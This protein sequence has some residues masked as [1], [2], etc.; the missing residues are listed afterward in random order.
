MLL[1]QK[2]WVLNVNTYL[3]FVEFKTILTKIK[4]KRVV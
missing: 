3:L 4:E 2:Y 1:A